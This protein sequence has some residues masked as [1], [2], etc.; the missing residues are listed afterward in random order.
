MEQD[1]E[2]KEAFGEEL[3]FTPRGWISTYRCQ[4]CNI[5]MTKKDP[6][7]RP[8][9]IASCSHIVCANCITTSYFVNLNNM[10]PVKDCGVYVNPAD[11]PTAF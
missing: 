6:A 2:D 10:C 3:W 9:M 1:L 7:K 8:Q 4:S 5:I 11:S